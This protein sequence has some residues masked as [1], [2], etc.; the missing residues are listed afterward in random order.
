LAEFCS[1]DVSLDDTLRDHIVCGINDEQ[2]QRQLLGESKLTLKKAIEIALSYE[3]AIKNSHT[4]QGGIPGRRNA[5]C[6]QVEDQP[7]CLF[8]SML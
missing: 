3:T 7:R 2:L 5:G 1:F 4:P 6:T 8:V